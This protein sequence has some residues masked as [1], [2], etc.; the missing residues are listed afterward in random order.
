MPQVTA[1]DELFGTHRV[2]ASSALR[3][4][5]EVCLSSE[6]ERLL[7]EVVADGFVVYCCG[8]RAA[9]CA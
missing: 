2:S 7:G 8:P 4:G 9:P 5:G 6:V 1:V 3:F